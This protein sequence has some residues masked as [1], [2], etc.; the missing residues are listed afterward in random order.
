MSPL[1]VPSIENKALL[2]LD[3]V[4]PRV[5]NIDAWFNSHSDF[6]GCYISRFENYAPSPGVVA[7]V[8]IYK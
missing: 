2:A 7:E 6:S 1:F 5:D 4:T 8:S 3:L